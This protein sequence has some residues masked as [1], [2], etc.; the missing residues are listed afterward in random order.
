MAVIEAMRRKGEG[1]PTEGAVADVL[2]VKHLS[3]S[4]TPGQARPGD[5]KP[6][7]LL[8]HPQPL[9]QLLSK[10]KEK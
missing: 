4:A 6:D 3:A 1:E 7:Q 5:S 10:K 9:H 8:R 2:Q